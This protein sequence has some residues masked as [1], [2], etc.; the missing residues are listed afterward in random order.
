MSYRHMTQRI[1]K[2]GIGLLM[3]VVMLAG[4]RNYEYFSIT[5]LEP[6]EIFLP[7]R[8]QTLLLLH[9]TPTDSVAGRGTLYN[10]F[11]QVYYDSTDRSGALAATAKN[12]LKEMVEMVGS[13]QIEN[14][15]TIKLLL[16][17]EATDFTESHLR[18]L[19]RLCNDAGTEAVIVLLSINKIV[20]YDIYYGSLGNDFGEFSVVM[21]SKWLLIDPFI[22]KLIDSK[23]I[24]DTLYMA[25]KN[26]YNMTDSES[27]ALSRQLLTESAEQNAINYG[28]YLSPHFAQ[29]QRMIFQ[30]G[31]RYIRR[32]YKEATNSN[33]TDA[34]TW[35]R[36][37]L[38]IQDNSLRAMAAFNLA[39]AN[40]MEGLLEPALDWAITSYDFFPDTLNGTYL[41][42]LRQRINQ[43]KEIILQMEK[44]E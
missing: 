26:P 43:Q 27:M 17:D 13:F 8:Y 41:R 34:A 30:R 16:P 36:R 1:S 19:R 32:G 44:Q 33:W 14:P 22:T 40:E 20:S 15:D 25:V 11:D 18:Q 5:V 24:R 9:N 37:V 23:T 7:D 10:I 39:V 29:T 21:I 4:C 42:I 3:V 12:T 6:G 35:W 28:M 2:T 38:P 31:H